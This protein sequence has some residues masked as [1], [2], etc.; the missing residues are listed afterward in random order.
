MN[1]DNAM[2]SPPPEWTQQDAWAWWFYSI[3]NYVLLNLMDEPAWLAL[4]FC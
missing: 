1:L 4:M 3:G 2:D